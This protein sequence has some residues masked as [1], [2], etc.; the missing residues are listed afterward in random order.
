MLY[1]INFILIKS[2]I[3][4]QNKKKSNNPSIEKNKLKLK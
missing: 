4:L 2:T 1:F 3:T